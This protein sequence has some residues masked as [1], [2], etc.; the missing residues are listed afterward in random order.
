MPKSSLMEKSK[1]FLEKLRISTGLSQGEIAGRLGISRPTY[2]LIEKGKKELTLSQAKLLSDLYTI[3]VEAIR[4]GYIP[5]DNTNNNDIVTTQ[6]PTK[7]GNFYFGVLNNKRG[8]EVVFLRTLNIDTNKPVLVRVHSECMTGDVFHSYRCDCGEQKDRSLSMISESGNGIFIYLRQE[9]RGIGLYEKIKSYILQEKG[10]DTHEANIILGHKPDYREYSWVKTVLDHLEVKEIKLITNNPS[11]VSDISRLGIKVVER[12][13]LVIESNH[14]N[15]RYFETKMRKFKHFFGKDESNY[16]YQF[17]YVESAEQVFE[18]GDFMLGM[19]KDPFLKICTGVYSDNHTLNDSHEIKK[20]ESIF[21]A[22]EHYEG[23]VPILHFTFKYSSDPI[24]DISKIRERMPYVKYIQLNDIENDH[25]KILKHANKFF[26][27]DIPLSNKTIDLV[28]NEDFV[29]ELITHKS[30]VL[31]DNSHGKGK[32]DSKANF[33][34]NI[35]LLLSKGLND[36]AVYGGFGPNSL[37][38]YFDLREHY[39]INF[40]I[41]AE[42]NLKTNKKLDLKKVKD[43]L[44]QLIKHKYEYRK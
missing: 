30:F 39:K 35:N 31:L 18:I 28:N 22:V 29:R 33:M 20:I 2:S 8:E 16:F 23:F 43:Y 38:L 13:P 26:L 34:N 10:Y 11:K 25:L 24:S 40:S 9:G 7:Y 42:T 44:A 15:R 14:Y 6:L 19:Q 4:T 3:P 21:K 41:D 5:K 1:N 12:I 17:S 37:K 36:V 32:Q 27:V